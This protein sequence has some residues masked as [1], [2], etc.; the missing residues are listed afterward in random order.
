MNWINAYITAIKTNLPRNQREDI[1][2]ELEGLLE[3]SLEADTGKASSELSEE[4]SLNWLKTREH[5][6]LVAIRY[7]DRRAL[8]DEDTFPLFKLTL[9]YALI[10]LAVAYTVLAILSAFSAGDGG[11]AVSLTRLGGNILHSGLLAFASI[12]LVFHFFGKHFNAREHLA[13][14]NPKDLPDPGKKWEQEPYASSIAGLVFS[15]IF[16]LFLNGFLTGV[17]DGLTNREAPALR[18]WLVEEAAALLPWINAVVIVSILMHAVMILRPRWSTATLAFHALV[19]LASAVIAFQLQNVSPMFR[20]VSDS[21]EH[22]E[23]VDRLVG[24]VNASA[25]MGLVTVALIS[26]FEA[27]RDIWRM[28]QLGGRRLTP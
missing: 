21:M 8:I 27:G 25:R 7:Q 17:L 11:Y 9:R 28:I 1:A 6:A 20:I 23:Q 22:A 3:E 2:S 19:G 14:W 13:A 5:P 18:A 4:E 16:L 24:I 10:G 15:G 12:T 26:L